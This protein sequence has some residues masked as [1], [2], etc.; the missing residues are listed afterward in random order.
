M[1]DQKIFR[2]VGPPGCGKTSYIERQC[3]RAVEKYGPRGALVVSYTNAG[4]RTAA[5]RDTGLDSKMVG[6]LHSVAKRT[7]GA[8]K[9]AEAAKSIAAFNASYPDYA[10]SVGD[11]DDDPLDRAGKV[12]PGDL[13]RRSVELKRQRMTPRSQWS[14]MELE[15]DRCWAYFKAQTGSVDFTDM[16][17]HALAETGPPLEESG[18]KVLFVDEAQ[19]LSALE[20]ALVHRWS[21]HVE[22]VVLVYDPAQALYGWRGSDPSMAS[23]TPDVVLKQSYRIPRRVQEHALSIIRRSTT[24]READYLPRAEDGVVHDTIYRIRQEDMDWIETLDDPFEGSAMVLASCD[25]MLL[26]IVREMRERG[27]A[28]HNPYNSRKNP[29]ARGDKDRAT[30]FDRLFA[31]SEIRKPTGMTA[32]NLGIV[33]DSVLREVLRPE[34]EKELDSLR[35]IEIGG[36]VV[37]SQR[38]GQALLRIFTDRM[39]EAIEDNDMPW[40]VENMYSTYRNRAEYQSKVWH[41]WKGSVGGLVAAADSRE[42]ARGVVTVGTIHSVKGGEADRVFL[43]P[44]LSPKGRDSLD[45]RGWLHHDAVMR[46]FYV[47]ATRAK[48]ELFVGQPMLDHM[49]YMLETGGGA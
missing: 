7:I 45:T 13:V 40:F 49:S 25:Y 21:E 8:T 1:S 14:E 36:G 46:Q 39:T 30:T 27:I 3:Q 5:G 24:Y 20:L 32:R 18:L 38:G 44:D 35:A 2:V 33:A 48:R 29:I 4:A 9:V 34:W 42:P 16:I 37:T 6:T 19:D 12:Q 31:F 10:L 15:F 47:G 11:K 17:E 26:N 28:Y 23:A 41:R 22:K 43:F